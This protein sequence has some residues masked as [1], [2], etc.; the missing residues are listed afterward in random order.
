MQLPILLLRLKLLPSGHP[1]AGLS[2]FSM[3]HRILLS[4]LR[5]ELMLGHGHE[6]VREFEPEHGSE[7]L[8]DQK[9]KDRAKRLAE[10]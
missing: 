8:P 2:S 6:P 5:F 9:A 7:L 10:V 3:R 4:I 1:S